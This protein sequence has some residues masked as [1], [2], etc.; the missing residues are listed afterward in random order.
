MD[1]GGIPKEGLLNLIFSLVKGLC[2]LGG[3]N[4]TS[5]LVDFIVLF[6]SLLP[7]QSKV[8]LFNF[9]WKQCREVILVNIALENC[10]FQQLRNRVWLV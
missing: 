2:K 8:S 3:R 4:V 10:I 9:T 6:L 1:F 7:N 5:F